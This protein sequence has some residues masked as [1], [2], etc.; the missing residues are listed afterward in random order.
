MRAFGFTHVV[1]AITGLF[2]ANASDAQSAVDSSGVPVDS[3][4]W[5]IGVTTGLTPSYHSG[6][7]R[8][9]ADRQ[10]GFGVGW[11]LGFTVH[12]RIGSHLAIEGRISYESRP[13][14]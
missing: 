12:N 1:L 5:H 14:T 11:Q 8:W 10:D 2:A 13:G 3:N 9:D 7:V 4:E 6:N